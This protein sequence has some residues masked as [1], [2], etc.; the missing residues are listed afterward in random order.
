[1]RG[2]ATFA[3]PVK[4]PPPCNR[5]C[6]YVYWLQPGVVVNVS[7][8]VPGGNGLQQTTDMDHGRGNRR[9]CGTW[10]FQFELSHRMRSARALFSRCDFEPLRA[11]HGPPEEGA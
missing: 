4:I 10:Y 11:G 9:C 3:I 7:W 2:S 8:H 5:L 6:A 1:M